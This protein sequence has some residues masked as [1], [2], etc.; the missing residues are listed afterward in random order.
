MTLVESNGEPRIKL[1]Q[2]LVKVT[3]PG[4]KRAY[5]LYGGNDHKTPLVDYMCLAD[6]D[7]P[8]AGKENGGVICR[9]PFRQ[10]HRLMIFPSRVLPLHHLVFDKGIVVDSDN[11]KA[12]CDRLLSETRTYVQ[13]QLHEEFPDTITRHENPKEYD[14]M[15][16]PK[17][18]S[19]LHELWEREA[20]IEERR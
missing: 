13:T 7:P 4:R 16:S 3:I 17:L 19:Y 5:R 8:K 6:E 2:D 14:V 12:S 1:S 9:N 10:Q 20:P 18:Y 11:N 15:V